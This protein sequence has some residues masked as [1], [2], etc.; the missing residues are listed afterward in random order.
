MFFFNRKHFS[1]KNTHTGVRFFFAKIMFFHQ[2]FFSPKLSFLS[3]RVKLNYSEL[4]RCKIEDV[5]PCQSQN[6][7][8]IQLI[9]GI[10]TI[11]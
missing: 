2:C 8:I 4:S 6:N 10:V 1:E 7:Y 9:K 5:S 11:V 3:E